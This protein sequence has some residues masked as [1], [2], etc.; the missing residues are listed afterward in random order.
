MATTH[1]LPG[2]Y[3]KLGVRPVIHAAGTTT[4]YGGSLMR[5]ETLAAMHEAAQV[6]VNIDELNAAAGS[7]IARLLG[8][9][10]AFVTSGAAAGLVLQAAACIAGDDPANIVRLPDSTGMKNEIIIQRAHRFQYDQAFRLA[11]AVLVEV[12]FGN[13]TVLRPG[14]MELFREA[15]RRVQARYPR[16]RA[17]AR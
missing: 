1:S 2:V 16:L 10:A 4:R 15:E 8:V 5:P 7:A 14:F 6:F 9:E 17:E 13:E 3:Q 12:R 11:G